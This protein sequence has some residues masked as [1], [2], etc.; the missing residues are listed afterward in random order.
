MTKSTS[1]IEGIIIMFPTSPSRCFGG[2]VEVKEAYADPN[3]SMSIAHLSKPQEETD[4]IL[5]H[6][7]V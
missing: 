5:A 4:E 6:S 2:L 3:F 7:S 1:A